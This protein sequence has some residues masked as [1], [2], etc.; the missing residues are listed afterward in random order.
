MVASSY[1]VADP[2]DVNSLN[3][4]GFGTDMPTIIN[5]FITGNI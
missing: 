1:T 5:E 4:V 2:K 3:I